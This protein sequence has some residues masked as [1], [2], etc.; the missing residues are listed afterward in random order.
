MAHTAGAALRLGIADKKLESVWEF[1]T[2]PLFTEAE[3]VALE[4]AIAGASQP[5]AVTDELFEKLKQHWTESQ[6]VEIVG[7]IAL[8]GFLNRFNDTMAT[9]LEAEPIE[10]GEKHLA[11]SGWSV[12]RHS[13]RA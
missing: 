12:G 4:L 11:K 5:N 13:R 7:V 10:V 2:S 1:R 8:F 9:P 6:I 3:R